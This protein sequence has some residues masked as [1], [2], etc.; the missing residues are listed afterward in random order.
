MASAGTVTVDFAA[1][2]ARFT[3]EL[4]K[5]NSRLAGIESGFNS[6]ARAAKTALQVFSAGVL[7]GFVKQAAQAADELGKTADKLGVSTTSLKAFQIAAAEAGVGLEQTN[8]L[9]SESQKR[10]GEAASGSGEAAKFIGLLGLNVKSLQQ[11][12][13]DELFRTYATAINNLSNR[14]EQLAAANALMGRSAQEAFSLIQAG[15][16][17]IDSATEFVNRFGL[18]LDRVSVKQIEQANDALGR[19]VILSETAGQRIAA[20]LAPFIEAFSN[21]ILN[22]A[23]STDQL[24]ARAAQFG[25]ILQTTFALVANAAR[26]AQAAFFAVAASVASA[27]TAVAEAIASLQRF[28]ANAV[29][30]LGDMQL[31]VASA[32]PGD[33]GRQLVD[34]FERAQEPVRNFSESL[35]QGAD[36]VARAFRASTDANLL[37]AEEATRKIQSFGEIQEGIVANLEASRIAAEQAVADQAARDAAARAGGATLDQVTGLTEQQNFDIATA[38]AIAAGEAQKQAQRDITD[39]TLE[40]LQRRSEA[41]QNVKNFEVASELAAQQAIV[42]ARNNAANAGIAALQA[43]A[44]QSKKVAIA[45]VLINKARA[46]AQAIQNTAVGA[47]L[48]LTTGDP[49]TAV[50]RAAAVK[51][52][53]ALQVAAIIASGYGEIQAING[54]GGAALGS[55]S[56]PVFTNPQASDQPFGATAQ[57]AVQVIIA[58]NVGFD[59]QIMDKIIQGIKEAVDDRDV[60][61]ISP[62]SRNA[63]E[64]LGA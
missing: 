10:L 40:E 1:E 56:N 55:P 16:P 27:L 12:A 36:S 18:A 41:F 37:K 24:Q 49:Y 30:S 48:Q 32:I 2:T 59:D 54:G 58:N 31:R 33:A 46:I 60:V 50:A 34:F 7:V 42:T 25:A 23:G 8:K 4:K 63:T 28:V 51:A 57:N 6:L 53:G 26:G 21:A 39:F 20:G 64:L 9:L 11:L 47:T 35:A 5:V 22:A 62:E 17:A 43:F 14:S 61:L 13:P 38:A 29:A 15:A 45:L 3:A 44:G 19:V 52:F